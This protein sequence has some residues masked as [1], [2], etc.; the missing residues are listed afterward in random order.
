M[1]S[2]QTSGFTNK[3]NQFADRAAMTMTAMKLFTEEKIHTRR[4]LPSRFLKVN[5]ATSEYV[6]Q[7]SFTKGKKN[8]LTFN[9]ATKYTL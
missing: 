2:K 3:Y 9:T 4:A 1:L 6:S 5:K 7:L 8:I